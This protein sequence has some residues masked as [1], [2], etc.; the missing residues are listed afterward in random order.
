MQFLLHPLNEFL[1]RQTDFRIN[2]F[3]LMLR[4]AC[5]SAALPAVHKIFAKKPGKEIAEAE[6]AQVKISG[7]LVG[8]SM[9]AH[10]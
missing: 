9:S 8:V 1:H 7:P 4:P 5:L 2:I 3:P 10:I 6:T